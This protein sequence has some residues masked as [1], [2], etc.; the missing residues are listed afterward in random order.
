M[1]TDK[2]QQAKTTLTIPAKLDQEVAQ[3]KKSYEY[4]GTHEEFIIE[5]VNA[6]M[7]T[8]KA[9]GADIYKKIILQ[10]VS[11]IDDYHYLVSIY[12]FVK[13]KHDRLRKEQEA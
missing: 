1:K 8:L 12:S 10:M 5:L 9:E 7:N 3:F 6:G 13:A 4:L 2:K 11:E